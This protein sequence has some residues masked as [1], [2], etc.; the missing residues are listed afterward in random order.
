MQFKGHF[1][2]EAFAEKSGIPSTATTAAA[3]N[4]SSSPS[5]RLMFLEGS[6]CA[7]CCVQCFASTSS[8]NTQNECMYDRGT[9]TSPHFTE[10][11]TE[12]PGG[13][14]GTRIGSHVVYTDKH[15]P[16]LFLSPIVVTSCWLFRLSLW[17]V[18]SLGIG[19][20]IFHAAD[21]TEHGLRARHPVRYS[22]GWEKGTV[23]NKTGKC[24][25]FALRELVFSE[26]ETEKKYETRPS[27]RNV[28]QRLGG[29]LSIRATRKT[30]PSLAGSES[31]FE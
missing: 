9:V 19:M 17:S 13:F 4:T 11:K 31:A 29:L 8:F 6:L 24:M 3:T 7:R 23:V 30:H 12:A 15:F 22:Q 21:L 26:K 2:W 10:E 18:G 5:S 1:L 14:Q 27:Q 20:L 25:S 28:N 16:T